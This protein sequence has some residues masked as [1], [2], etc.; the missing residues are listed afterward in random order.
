MGIFEMGKKP[1][2]L[3]KDLPITPG[4]PI[5]PTK[6]PGTSGTELGLRANREKASN[7]FQ[8]AA[9]AEQ[10][11]RAKRQAHAAREDV[12][13][14]K[15][16]IKLGMKKLKE[17]VACYG[18]AVKAVPSILRERRNGVRDKKMAK[19][20]EEAEKKRKKLEEEIEKARAA[21]GEQGKDETAA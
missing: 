4:E 1:A 13:E 2:P 8:R 11:Y 10:A 17:G 15:L 3:P 7:A 16:L 18:R 20:E 21:R 5:G 19:R 9:K 6:R 14:G 12:T